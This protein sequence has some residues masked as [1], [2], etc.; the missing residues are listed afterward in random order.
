MIGTVEV[1]EYNLSMVSMSLVVYAASAY[2]VHRGGHPAYRWLVNQLFPSEADQAQRVIARGLFLYLAT[3][4]FPTAV[5]LAISFAGPEL[6]RYGVALAG[7]GAVY[8][9]T[10]ESFHYSESVYRYQWYVFGIGLSAV[11]SL[12]ALADPTLRIVAPG[13]SIIRY[14]AS[15]TLTRQPL[16]AY[17]VAALLPALLVMVLL[18]FEVSTSYFGVALLSLAAA[19]GVS[20]LFWASDDLKLLG[21]PLRDQP[22][23]Y[24]LPFLAVGF[25]ISVVGM[26]LSATES[27]EIVLAALG[28]ATLYCLLATVALR[29]TAAALSDGFP[30][31]GGVQRRA[32]PDRSRPPVLWPGFASWSTGRFSGWASPGRLS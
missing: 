6:A 27:K 13:V 24:T 3:G 23:S 20:G 18:R 10:A 14:A 15:A 26:G 16:W 17:P 31:G 7:I 22:G 9:V 32:D 12:I 28:L 4:L 21:R 1:K 25:L 29:Q 11:G 2:Q 19:Y 5:L 30:A 8:L